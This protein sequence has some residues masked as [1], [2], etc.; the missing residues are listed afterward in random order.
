MQVT[1]HKGSHT[2]HHH[3][4]VLGIDLDDLQILNGVLGVT[5]ITS[6]FFAGV[7]TGTTTL[8]RARRTHGTMGQTDTVTAVLTVEAM[9]F[10]HTSKS[11]S[12]GV[13]ASID[14]LAWLEPVGLDAFANGKK[15]RLVLHAE[16]ED[17]TLGRNGVGGEMSEHRLGYVFSVLP[18]RAHLDGKVAMLLSSLVRNDLDPVELEDGAGDTLAG[19]LVKDGCHALLGRDGTRSMGQRIRLAAK[20][21]RRC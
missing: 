14:I 9:S 15:T 1:D 16:L 10:H 8:S 11:L 5:H 6:H 18:A 19:F 4:P 17:V 7:N 20:S 12:F 3:D 13:G 21:R 2:A